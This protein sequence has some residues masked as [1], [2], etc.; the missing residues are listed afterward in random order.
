MTRTAPELAAPLQ[1]I[2]TREL[3]L[4]NRIHEVSAWPPK[5]QVLVLL[6]EPFHSEY[7][8]SPAL[9]YREINNPHYWKSEYSL[10]DGSQVVGCG[11][12]VDGEA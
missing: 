8:G 11:F 6:E 3:M 12:G 4:G 1:E 2:L 7:P 10:L 5:C 9:V